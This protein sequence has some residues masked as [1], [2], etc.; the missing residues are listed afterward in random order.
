MATFFSEDIESTREA[1]TTN[2][3]RAHSDYQRLTR[4]FFMPELVSLEEA[5][6]LIKKPR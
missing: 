3:K 4:A 1:I 6:S 2:I 5:L